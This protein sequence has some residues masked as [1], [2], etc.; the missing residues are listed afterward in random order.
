MQ[1]KY[2]SRPSLKLAAVA[3]CGSLLVGFSA[4]A[5]LAADNL[6]DPG[7]T[8]GDSPWKVDIIYENDT[9][10]RGKDNAGNNV[11]L[12]KF[13]NTLQVE[14][15][16]AMGDG[17]ALHSVLRGTYDGVYELNKDQYG[18]TAGS[19]T[20]S[21]LKIQNTAGPVAASVGLG[22]P[23]VHLG[24]SVPF[25][26]G[27]GFTVVDAIQ[28]GAGL[29][30]LGGPGG[31]PGVNKFIDPNYGAYATGLDTPPAVYGSGAGLV[32]LG[33][34]WNS[35]PRGVSFAVP[36]RPCDI[37]RRGCADFGGYGDKK[38]SELESPEFNDRADFI[39]EFYLKK[40]YNLGDGSDFFVK[41]GKQQ[42]VWG[43]TDLFR[44]LDV[45]NPVDYSRN[46][47]YDELQDIR[48]PMWIVQ[49][50]WRMGGSDMLQER[51]LQVVW[52]FDKF[53]AN[54]LG[55]GGTPNAILDAG[56]FFRGMK[57]LWDNGSTVANFAGFSAPGTPAPVNGVW[58]ATNFGPNQIG[59]RDVHLPEW[60]LDNTQ[61]G[62]KFEGVTKGGLNFSLN[63]LTYRS[64]LPSLHSINGAAINAFTGA[65]GN[66]SPF[67]GPAQGIPV[68]SLIAFDMEFPRVNLVGG[69]MDIQSETLGAAFRLEGALTHG[70]EFANTARPGLYSKNKVWRSVIGVDRPTF[71][72]WINPNRTTLFSAQLFY[73]HIFDHEEHVMPGG[74]I[75]MPDWE[76]NFI[77]TLLIK[78]W[79][80][81][82]RVSPQIIMARDFKARAWVASPQVEWLVTNDLKLTF[83]ANIKGKDDDSQQRWSWDDARSANPWAPYTTYVGQTL[84]PGS[85]G[86][87]GLEPLG[88]FR[89]GPIGAAWKENEL[90]VTLRY[91]F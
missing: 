36:V 11:G 63:A 50:E 56:S 66:T 75:G 53:R 78:S 86:V 69:S 74:L 70:E 58:F 91:K 6:P 35:N 26:G 22:L 90:Y 64:Q 37:D 18:K 19:K 14:A 28:A 51:N 68:G 65:P 55:Q 13:R 45:I 42:V 47:I 1:N 72:P 30:N 10:Y 4:A 77:G 39:R 76:D 31:G 16:K 49:G 5:A 62:M 73:Q 29:P 33:Q 15:D 20:A 57:N 24:A 89:A 8:V 48:I 38:Q 61:L 43:R 40:T 3:L 34:A 87:G 21:D 80:M 85:F 59:L 71:I 79:L 88:R 44:V 7:G 84:N 46:N 9:H 81:G 17:W 82:D 54:N 27:V 12:S 67:S 23:P 52:N 41:V 2:M 25:G 83:G 32:M 60:S